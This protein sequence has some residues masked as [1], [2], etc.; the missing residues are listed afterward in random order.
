VTSSVYKWIYCAAVDGHSIVCLLSICNV[1]GSFPLGYI[2]TWFSVIFMTTLYVVSAGF[3][4][5]AFH[6]FRLAT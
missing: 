1:M 3:P 2:L 6:S 5:I 4:N